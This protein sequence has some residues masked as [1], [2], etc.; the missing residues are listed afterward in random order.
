[1]QKNHPECVQFTTIPLKRRRCDSFKA[2]PDSREDI[3][4][5]TN[6][7]S[8]EAQWHDYSTNSKLDYYDWDR[9]EL[10]RIC[11]ASP[12][13]ATVPEIPEGEDSDV[14]S[15]VGTRSLSNSNP[16]TSDIIRSPP[17]RYKAGQAVKDFLFSQQ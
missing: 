6:Y 8:I 5:E 11:N 4:P 10:A 1:M 12:D 13:F 9:E 7:D 14:E 16:Y 3:I 17:N 2:L 15:S